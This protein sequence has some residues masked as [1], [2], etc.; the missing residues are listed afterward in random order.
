MKLAL[1]VSVPKVLHRS[2]ERKHVL[3]VHKAEV[4]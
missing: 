2:R 4:S 3:R 1:I